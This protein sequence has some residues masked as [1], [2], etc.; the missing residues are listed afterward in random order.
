MYASCVVDIILSVFCFVLSNLG[1]GVRSQPGQSPIS[2]QFG[3][4]GVELVGQD[5]GEGHAFLRLIGGVSEHQAL[6]EEQSQ[7]NMEQKTA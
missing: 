2:A 4:L 7:M 6:S 5:D 3:H 1:F